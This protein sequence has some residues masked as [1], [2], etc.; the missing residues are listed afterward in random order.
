MPPPCAQRRPKVGCDFS[1]SPLY[2]GETAGVRG[3]FFN[4][5][6]AIGNRQYEEPLTLTLSPECR[7]EGTGRQCLPGPSSSRS[8]SA[9]PARRSRTSWTSS[10]PVGS[11]RELRLLLDRAPTCLG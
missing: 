1:P 5:Q 8:S 4:R 9:A 3:G 11:T 2:S 7:G 6:S 10:P